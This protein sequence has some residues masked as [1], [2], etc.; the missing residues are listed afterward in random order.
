MN[1]DDVCHVNNI[2]SL[3]MMMVTP[4]VTTRTCMMTMAM[5]MVAMMV[6]MVVMVMTM[7]TM[8]ITRVVLTAAARS[9]IVS[10][11]GRAF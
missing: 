11:E 9:R 10:F 3:V 8:S 6:V 2:H 4:P 7:T 5:M 1:G